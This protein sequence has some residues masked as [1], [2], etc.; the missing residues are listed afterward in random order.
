MGELT[1]RNDISQSAISQHLQ[2]LKQARLIDGRQRGRNMIYSAKPDGLAP[3]V[4]W[5]A[6]NKV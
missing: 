5:I 3:L 4:N 2:W 6:A 1:Q